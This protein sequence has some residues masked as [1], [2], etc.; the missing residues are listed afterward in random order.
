MPILLGKEVATF[1]SATVRITQ[2]CHALRK[3]KTRLFL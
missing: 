2:Q 1:E 3:I